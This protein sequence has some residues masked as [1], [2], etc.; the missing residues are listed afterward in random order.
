MFSRNS[1]LWCICA[2]LAL[3]LQSPLGSA[4]EAP[5]YTWKPTDSRKG[6]KLF[7]S[8]DHTLSYDAVKGITVLP[9]A[10]PRLLAVLRAFENYPAWYTDCVEARLIKAP[11]SVPAQS[12]AAAADDPMRYASGSTWQLYVRQSASPLGDRW[13]VLESQLRHGPKGSV[14]FTFN[15]LDKH[16]YK[17]PT[18]LT[19]MRLRGFW[20]LRPLGPARTL[21]TFVLD[22]DPNVSIPAFLVNPAIED[23]VVD[24][25]LSLLKEA[26]PKKERQGL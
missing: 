5:G 7:T 3:A 17:P 8:D 1:T 18:D 21:V 6:V 2:A 20:E 19:R 25:L 10:A 26:A 12:E 23:K 15:T 4:A 22:A 9:V 11:S 16:P 13:A 14:T 24:T